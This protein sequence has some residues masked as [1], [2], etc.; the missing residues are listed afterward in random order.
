MRKG[1]GKKIFKHQISYFLCILIKCYNG[2]LAYNPSS[3]KKKIWDVLILAK[4][5]LDFRLLILRKWCGEQNLIGDKEV[6]FLVAKMQ[7]HSFSFE[8]SHLL[9]LG[10][11]LSMQYTIISY[12]GSF[13]WSRTT[14]N[15]ISMGHVMLTLEPISTKWSSR[16]LMVLSK[17]TRAWT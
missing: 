12:F 3:Q 9:R 1:I 11:T 13:C 7:W 16:C 17:P 15:Q 4:N 10:N 14:W 6:S 2:N 5:W 8:L